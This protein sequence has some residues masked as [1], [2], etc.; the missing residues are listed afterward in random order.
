MTNGD[1]GRRVRLV[2][3]AAVLILADAGLTLAGQP[4]AY[5][6]GDRAEAVEANPLA[7]PLLERGPWAFAAVAVGWAGLVAAVVIGWRHPAVGWLAVGMA[8]AHA[9]GGASWVVRAGRWGAA[10]AVAYLGVAAWAS[11][12]CW[13]RAAA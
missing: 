12:W 8:A 5:W 11:A 2:L 4:A 13:R 9:V 10:A 7:R 3:P 1:A 6:A